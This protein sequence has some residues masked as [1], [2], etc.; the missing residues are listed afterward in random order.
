MTM[1]ID[2]TLAN[3]SAETSQYLPIT[4]SVYL[5]AAIILAVFVVLAR[6]VDYVFEKIFLRLTS[7]TKTD[8][9]DRIVAALKSPIF[10]A[11]VLLG[12]FTSLHYLPLGEKIFYYVDN[13]L[14]T[15]VIAIAAI[16]AIRVSTILI[17]SIGKR[18]T[19]KTKS[20]LDDELLPL[21]KN[22]AKIII[23]FIALMWTLAAWDIDITPLL[24]S[25]GIV[26]IALAFAAQSTVANLFGGIAIYF[27]K[28]FRIGER[29]QL[30][31]GEIGD[32][33]EIGIR[34]T[35]IRTLDHTMI[36]LPNDKI[37][38]SKII[39]FHQPVAEMNVKINVGVAYGSDTG[40]VRRTLLKVAKSAQSVMK[41]PAP[42]VF[43]VEH[44]DSALKFLLIAWISDPSK[45]ISA[46]D[47][48]NEGIAREFKKE[49]IDIPFPTQTVYLKK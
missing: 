28:P 40:K 45:R 49:K 48:I 18:V 25:A 5:N 34:S 16:S 1:A 17:D 31:S 44:A 21:F 43:F 47:E 10:Y 24:A 20:T 39:N 37:V 36:I 13:L 38:N 29:I 23:I 32:V 33:A 3:I 2:P 14:Q 41:N 27:D 22:V 6:V 9:D 11:V 35:R 12:A 15:A 42:D 46:L 7:H 30:E 4:S 8:I 26:G 19:A